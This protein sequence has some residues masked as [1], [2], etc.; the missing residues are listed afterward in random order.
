M[1]SNGLIYDTIS[2][3]EILQKL[4]KQIDFKKW[5][6]F[7]NGATSSDSTLKLQLEGHNSF[8]DTS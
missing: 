7:R 2:C 4:Y 5:I 6:A 3:K 8:K 1:D